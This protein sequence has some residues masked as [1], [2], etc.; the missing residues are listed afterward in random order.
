MYVYLCLDLAQIKKICK[1]TPEN[2]YNS[3]TTFTN[4]VCN[5]KK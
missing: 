4:L 5:M 3:Y 2:V 1:L